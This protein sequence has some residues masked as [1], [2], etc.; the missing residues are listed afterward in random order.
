MTLEELKAL[1]EKA[2]PGP[3]RRHEL[4]CHRVTPD[5]ANGIYWPEKIKDRQH[6][7]HQLFHS[8]GERPEDDENSAFVSTARTALP[9]SLALIE[10]MALKLEE[11]KCTFAQYKESH[12]AKGTPDGEEKAFRNALHEISMLEALAAYEAFKSNVNGD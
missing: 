5:E 3:W 8:A 1:I 9:T 2:T 7:K 10:Q 11:A 6:I 4:D 12:K